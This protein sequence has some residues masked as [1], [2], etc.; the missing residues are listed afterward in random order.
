M[1]LSQF[2]EHWQ[3]IENP[4]RGEEAR[5]DT[6][7][8]RM[9]LAARSPETSGMNSESAKVGPRV[10]DSGLRVPDSAPAPTA[11]SSTAAHSD[12]DKILGDLSRPSTHDG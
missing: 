4:F 8:G 7:F 12:F 9:A 5:H 3:I 2:F 11:P 10:I 6:V 1:N